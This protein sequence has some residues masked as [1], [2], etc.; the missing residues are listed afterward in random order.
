M[1]TLFPFG[2]R[3]I[4]I[5][6]V[7]FTLIFICSLNVVYILFITIAFRLVC[8]HFS[9]NVLLY[10]RKQ[11]SF[12]FSFESKW[13]LVLVS[14]SI[15]KRTLCCCIDGDGGGGGVVLLLLLL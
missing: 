7:W 11:L 1:R 5:L 9:P 8:M 14:V 13:N 15:R 3:V 4:A 6:L 12:S 10:C 2:I